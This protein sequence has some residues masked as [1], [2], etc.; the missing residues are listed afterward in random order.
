MPHLAAPS[1]G[2]APTRAAKPGTDFFRR[3]PPSCFATCPIEDRREGL[4]HDA[5]NL[6]GAL[7]LYCDLLAVPGVLKPEHR[8]YAEEVR[9][10]GSRSGALI[11]H[12]MERVVPLPGET[13][14]DGTDR[15]TSALP[16]GLGCAAQAGALMSTGGPGGDAETAAQPV[17]LRAVVE[18]CAGLL[19]RVAGGRSIEV[20]IGAAAAVPVRVAEE[21]VERILVNLV[22]NAAAA[23]AGHPPSHSPASDLNGSRGCAG[24]S[25]AIK[26]VGTGAV[27]GSRASI[28]EIKADGIAGVPPGTIRVGVGL[29]GDRVGEAR[30]WPFRRVRLVV[31]DS[32]CGMEPEQLEWLLRG[33]RAPARS[34]HG[35]GFRV[36]RELVEASGG[37]L[38]AM[39]ALGTGTR[40]QIEWPM[41]AMAALESGHGEAT[42]TPDL[43][44][45][46]QPPAREPV[47]R[48]PVATGGPPIQA[49]RSGDVPRFAEGQGA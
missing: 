10:L 25:G 29:L 14:A 22:R 45:K 43:F 32:G 3:P 15:E 30:P 21:V 11:E 42:D 16:A 5:R 39:S 2:L 33:G 47:R 12:L 31:E 46:G 37:E 13:S 48:P 36:V 41:A 20:S 8:H 38:R 4:L 19:S 23:L 9:L 27:P 18:R 24:A 44:G 17:S 34:N 6:M 26:R 1:P 28:R 40:V 7:G 35:I 49:R